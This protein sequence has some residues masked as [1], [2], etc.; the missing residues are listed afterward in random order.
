MLADDPR[1]KSLRD[2]PTKPAGGFLRIAEALGPG[3]RPEA[4]EAREI[5]PA[6]EIAVALMATRNPARIDERLKQ[7]AALADLDAFKDAAY[8]AAA[9]RRAD[10]PGRAL[11]SRHSR[12]RSPDRQQSIERRRAIAGAGAYRHRR[13][14]L[15]SGRRIQTSLGDPPAP[16]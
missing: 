12:P 7:V 8:L 16:R 9:R 11:P 4:P 6:V 2:A 15:G 14:R 5:A 1:L 3:A 10:L 13:L